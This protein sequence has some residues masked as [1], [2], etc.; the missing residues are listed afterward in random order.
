MTTVFVIS[1]DGKPLMPM[2]K[3]GK[4]RHMLKDGRAVIYKRNPFTIQLTYD[5]RTYIQP[6]ELCIDTGYQEVG[7]SIKSEFREYESHEYDLLKDEKLKHDD[8]RSYRKTRRNR[9]TRYRKAR[10]NNRKATKPEGW[11]PP[12]IKN[13]ADR[14][15]D[16]IS[17]YCEICPITNIYIE[18]GQF[19]TQVLQAIEEGKPIPQ[20]KGY[21]QGSMYQFD[22]LREAVFQRDNHTC[23]FCGKSAIKDG[24]ILHLHHVY[25]WKNRHADRLDELATCCHRCHTSAN[26]KPGGKLWGYD[27]K[28]KTFEGAAFMNS[29]RY[30]IVDKVKQLTTANVEITFGAITKRNRLTLGISKTHAND[31]YSMGDFHPQNRSKTEYYKKRRRNDRCLEKFYDAKYIDIR[32]SKTKSGKDLGCERTNRRELRNS[33]KNLRICHGKKV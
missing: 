7:L 13:K 17:K 30:Y 22:T 20:G 3:L 24:V 15:V 28:M 23:I 1:K 12:S 9:K 16:L 6:I 25:F 5:T 2:N 10:F 31:A 4:V 21:Q 14:Q 33:E 18:V 11:F 32:D 29:V 8:C 26:H 27:G 19:D